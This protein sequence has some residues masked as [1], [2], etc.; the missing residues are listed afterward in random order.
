[1]ATF[2]PVDR[3]GKVSPGHVASI[4]SAESARRET[5]CFVRFAAIGAAVGIAA[6]LYYRLKK[7]AA[8]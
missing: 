5:V 4:L 6:T 3:T 8:V 1:M 2:K 7:T